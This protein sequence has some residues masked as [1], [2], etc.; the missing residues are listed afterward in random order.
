[1]GVQV[2][3]GLAVVLT[4][5]ET[6][7]RHS[8]EQDFSAFYTFSSDIVS[9]FTVVSCAIRLPTY[10]LCDI[11]FRKELRWMITRRS[12]VTSS[13][14][15]PSYARYATQWS[16]PNRDSGVGECGWSISAG[17][18]ASKSSSAVSQGDEEGRGD[19]VQRN[20]QPNK[21]VC[22]FRESPLPSFHCRVV[23]VRVRV[24]LPLARLGS[25]G[26]R[27]L[28]AGG[29]GSTGDW[30]GAVRRSAERSEGQAPPRGAQ[31]SSLPS[32]HPLQPEHSQERTK[33]QYS[34]HRSQW[35]AVHSGCQHRRMER[36]LARR[37]ATFP[38]L[39]PLPAEPSHPLRL[40]PLSA[41]TH[42]LRKRHLL[43]NL[44]RATLKTKTVLCVLLLLMLTRLGMAL[45][46]VWWLRFQGMTQAWL[47]SP[48]VPL[49]VSCCSLH[50][51]HLTAC[52]K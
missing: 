28:T 50:Y 1:M 39:R 52:D 12:R 16:A 37:D 24:E 14:H 8:L 43:R 46:V 49:P 11:T 41:T 9:L 13:L 31:A 3:N 2:S 21:A 15:I 38:S 25:V 36:S 23:P 32:P 19:L 7:S 26:E 33:L 47:P 4:F 34:S 18:S 45:T 5:W 10:C 22:P 42:S 30:S 40:T 44:R 51:T 29:R 6:V 27:W 20:G 48:L 35:A 17:E